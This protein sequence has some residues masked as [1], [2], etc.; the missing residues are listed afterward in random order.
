[1][2]S[3]F[4]H[5]DN[6]TT[7]SYG[8]LKSIRI[9]LI[10]QTLLH[11][12]CAAGAQPPEFGEGENRGLLADD[13]I[14]EASGLAA[15]ATTPAILWANNDSGDTTRIF[16]V[17]LR[18]EAYGT[19]YLAGSSARD[20]EDIAVGPGPDPTRSYIFVADIGDNDA[21]YETKRIYRVAEPMVDT[22]AGNVTAVLRDVETITYRY[23]DG[24]R[25][26]ECVMVDPLTRDIYIIS[27][28]EPNVK[29]YRAP[30]PQSTTET[31]T[32]E[33]VATLDSITWVTAGDISS[34]GREILVKNYASVHY[35]ERG[36]EETIAEA[37]ERKPIL[38]PY[39]PEP[40]GEA[41]TWLR[42][43]SGYY[44]VS[45]EP[46][47]F[48]AS[49]WF[50]PRRSSSGIGGSQQSRAEQSALPDLAGSLRTDTPHMP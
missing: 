46:G 31:I 47:G 12:S 15:S 34:D 37:F 11:L 2:I 35:W 29:V 39:T 27:K 16:A 4:S 38:L 30:W 13:L 48:D 14:A 49:L 8:M 17:G 18:G 40:Q 45:E 41:V 20:W 7:M 10:C 33:H 21:R 36:E 6:H 42:D 23:P 44:T 50:Y 22:S 32:L 26:A 9:V 5:D 24:A 19:F 3:H 1:M 28:R 25:D 43:G